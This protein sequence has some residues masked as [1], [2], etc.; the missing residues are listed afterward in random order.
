MTHS[1]PLLKIIYSELYVFICEI[2]KNEFSTTSTLSNTNEHHTRFRVQLA[3]AT[4]Y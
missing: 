3:H 2:L 4:G 1:G